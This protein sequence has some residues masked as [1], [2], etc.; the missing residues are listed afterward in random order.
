MRSGVKS[1]LLDPAVG[2]R[3]AGAVRHARVGDKLGGHSRV[4]VGAET[5]TE[6]HSAGDPGDG[7]RVGKG[8]PFHSLVLL[9]WP[10]RDARTVRYEEAS[11]VGEGCWE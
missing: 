1:I 5:L 3:G 8:N 4:L 2:F 10:S 11:V 9:F 6:D 7:G